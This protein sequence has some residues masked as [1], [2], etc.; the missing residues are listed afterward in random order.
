MP[1]DRSIAVL[2][3]D[4]FATMCR[5][6]QT[7]LNKIGFANVE[8]VRDG[9]SALERLRSKEFHLIIADWRMEPMSGL[10]L[11]H[12]IRQ[13][14]KLQN[15]RFIL[16]SADANPQL[17]DTVETLGAHGFLRKPFAAETLNAAIE[18][19]FNLPASRSP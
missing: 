1:V 17:A 11:L 9:N 5:I 8:H 4:D 6:I 13:D 16:T 14:G 12:L 19:A 18:R 2:V 15:A 3:V 7:L 10:Q